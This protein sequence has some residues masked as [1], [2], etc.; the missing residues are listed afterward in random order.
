M[1][2]TRVHT[3]RGPL[4]GEDCSADLG[5]S[6]TGPHFL[7]RVDGEVHIMGEDSSE[8]WSFL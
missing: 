8:D 4:L 7:G 5:P 2:R 1:P 3:G 6:V